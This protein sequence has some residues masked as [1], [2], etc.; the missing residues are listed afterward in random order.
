MPE[1]LWPTFGS[2]TVKCHQVCCARVEMQ[3]A[4]QFIDS[5][6]HVD[7]STCP[8]QHATKESWHTKGIGRDPELSQLLRLVLQKL[9][10]ED[11]SEVTRSPEEEV[12]SVRGT[13]PKR[14]HVAPSAAFP[15]VKRRRNG[16][17]LV[18]A[19]I[20]LT[21]PTAV[22]MPA[23]II[24]PDS[25]APPAVPPLAPPAS[26]TDITAPPGMGVEGVL[27]D[28]RKSL[29]ALAP[30]AQTGAS[31]TPFPRLVA[32]APLGSPPVRLPEHQVQ[33]QNPSR[34]A[35]L[36][37]SKLLAGINAPTIIAPPLAALWGLSDSWQNAVSDL[38]CQV[39]SLVAA[40]TSNPLQALNSSS[41]AAPAPS[42][43]LTS[44][45]GHS[46]RLAQR[47]QGSGSGQPY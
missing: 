25:P 30:T 42:T 41:S 34:L 44:P 32:S 15:P 9:V 23:Q 28:I 27:A 21:P 4:T 3:K 46:K 14:S 26:I 16:K 38:K 22:S 31:P 11:S 20:N 6:V 19:S 33:D 29:A 5:R 45:P 18:P 39:D 7:N 8:G 36:E 40:H 43:G 12:G 24:L 13:R 17:A 10:S 37:V 2:N 1:Q 47:Q 35:L